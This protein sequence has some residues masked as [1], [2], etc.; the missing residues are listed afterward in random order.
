[1]SIYSSGSNQVGVLDQL[2]PK[3]ITFLNNVLDQVSNVTFQDCQDP[4]EMSDD[5]N[6]WTIGLYLNIVLG[7][8]VC[9][10]MVL[11][12]IIHIHLKLHI[13]LE[14]NLREWMNIWGSTYLQN[15]RV[16]VVQRLFCLLKEGI[17]KNYYKIDDEQ[18]GNK[19]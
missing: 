7:I 1:M 14:D 9:G 18:Q 16:T 13:N 10:P 4:T 17:N 5:P 6:K 2:K 19:K 3:I 8:P 12:C 11:W 15:I